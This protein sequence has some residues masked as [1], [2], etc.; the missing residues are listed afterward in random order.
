[1]NTDSFDRDVRPSDVIDFLEKGLLEN[2]VLLFKAEPHLY[3]LLTELLADERIAVR[4]GTSALVESLAEED[5]G[6]AGKAVAALLPLLSHGRP[7]VRGD[8]AYLLGIIGRAEAREALGRL[9]GDEDNGVREAAA[10]ALE[11]IADGEHT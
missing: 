9:A 4:L 3:A 8:A 2:L 10:E 11:M 7:T 1:M 6:N 5:L